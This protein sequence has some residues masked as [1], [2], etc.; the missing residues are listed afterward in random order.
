MSVFTKIAEDR[1]K[2]AMEKGEFDN[3]P[4]KGKFIDLSEYFNTPRHLRMAY[5]LLK[6]SNCLPH[7]IELKKE[8]EELREQRKKCEKQ[9]EAARL[10]REI[11][12]KHAFLDILMERYK[13]GR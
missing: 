7:E 3:N 5:S 8:I 9:E 6:N 4:C 10:T 11:N 13:K 1:I 2:E 12:E